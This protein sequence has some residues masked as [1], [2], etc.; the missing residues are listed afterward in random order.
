VKGIITIDK[1]FGAGYFFPV[2]M[3]N[4]DIEIE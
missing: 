1:D 4:A 3:E 2:V